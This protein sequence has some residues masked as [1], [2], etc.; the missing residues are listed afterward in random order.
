MKTFKE[1]K[2]KMEVEASLPAKKTP[3]WT[4]PLSKTL[5]RPKVKKVSAIVAVRG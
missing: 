4:K 3:K 5:K 1:F 2:K